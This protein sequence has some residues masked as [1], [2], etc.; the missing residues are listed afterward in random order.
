MT[1]CNFLDFQNYLLSWQHH[2][3]RGTIQICSHDIGRDFISLLP[4][5]RLAT[6]LMLSVPLALS[7]KEQ[8]AKTGKRTTLI[9]YFLL[10][11]W[12]QPSVVGLLIFNRPCSLGAP[13]WMMGNA[14]LMIVDGL[15][16]VLPYLI[17]F[18]GMWQ[19]IALRLLFMWTSKRLYTFPY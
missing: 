8:A 16:K 13:H 2:I 7:P 3:F 19:Q 6:Q 15:K 12:P 4:L 1:N 9:L 17:I 11:N 5:A 10:S 18:T 14:Q